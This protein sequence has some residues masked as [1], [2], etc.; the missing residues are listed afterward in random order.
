M[1]NIL[2]SSQALK[3][4]SNLWVLWGSYGKDC[5][6]HKWMHHWAPQCWWAFRL[7][8]RQDLHTTHTCSVKKYLSVSESWFLEHGDS[9]FF[10]NHLGSFSVSRNSI[11]CCEFP[12]FLKDPECHCIFFSTELWVNGDIWGVGSI[13]SSVVSARICRILTLSICKTKSESPWIYMELLDFSNVIL[14]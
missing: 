14:T 8:N 4:G 12:M 1:S 6:Y 7:P 9:D 11:I 2:L 10:L 5:S 3:A 13:S